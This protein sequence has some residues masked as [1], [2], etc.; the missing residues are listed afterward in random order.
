M[1]NILIVL[2]SLITVACVIP[3]I[4]DILKKKTKPRVVSWFTWSLL[5]GIAGAASLADHQYAAAA[6]SLS[7]TTECMIVVILGLKY[8]DREFTKFDI[9]CQVGALVGLLL[10][11]LL[12][13]PAIAVIVAVAID[14]IGTL[15][16]VKHAW[17]KPGEETPITF[18]LAGFAA[19]LTVFAATSVQVT[20]L[21]NPL[22]L[23]A[24]NMTMTAII[25]TRRKTQAVALK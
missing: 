21:A 2:S 24:I 3:Y 22:Y 9:S 19:L 12:D 18:F 14:F 20:A 23:V 7:A 25:L 13:S 11:F 4:L 16:T 5:S 8:G 15:P 17:Q 6:L 1:K 10:W